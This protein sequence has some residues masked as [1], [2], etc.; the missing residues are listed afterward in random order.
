MAWVLWKICS[1]S[2]PALDI[3]PG[4]PSLSDRQNSFALGK[5]SDTGFLLHLGGLC[6]SVTCSAG[7]MG[8]HPSLVMLL[9]I[10]ATLC[11]MLVPQPAI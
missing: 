3:T 5:V 7:G 10:L 6:E 4:V 9:F 2:L 1:P 8:V 11:G